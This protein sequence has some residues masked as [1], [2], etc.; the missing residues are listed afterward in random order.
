MKMEEYSENAPNTAA[1]MASVHED[2]VASESRHR[3]ADMSGLP[4][5]QSEG[6]IE[7]GSSCVVRAENEAG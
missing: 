5:T 1:G 6:E 2:A 3:V 7:I 4:T